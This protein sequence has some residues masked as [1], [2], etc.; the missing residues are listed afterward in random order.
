MS[1]IVVSKN[2]ANYKLILLVVHKEKNYQKVIKINIRN[3]F[4]QIVCF[5]N[6]NTPTLAFLIAVLRNFQI[7]TKTIPGKNAFN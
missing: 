6:R 4:I 3:I 7:V 5:F 2:K 1:K